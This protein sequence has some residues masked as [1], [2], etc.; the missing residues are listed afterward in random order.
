[1]K[2]R[3]VLPMILTGTTAS[4]LAGGLY[5]LDCRTAGGPVQDCWLTGLPIAG[6]GAGAGAGFRLCYETLN[7][8]LRRRDDELG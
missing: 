4:F 5:I 6:L 8:A 3:D 7:P 2:A 1:M